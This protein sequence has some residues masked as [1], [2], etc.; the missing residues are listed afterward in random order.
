MRVLA[1]AVAA[2]LVGPVPLRAQPG[3]TVPQTWTVAAG[4]EACHAVAGA[5]LC[6]TREPVPGENRSQL[7][8]TMRVDGATWSR[9]MPDVAP[10]DVPEETWTLARRDADGDGVAEF[11]VA[12]TP[13]WEWNTQHL[14][15]TDV[16]TW[17]PSWPDALRYQTALFGEEGRGDDLVEGRL[18]V[19]EWQFAPDTTV[20][21]LLVARRYRVGS[22]TLDPTG[23]VA[24]RTFT[25]RDERLMFNGAAAWIW[26]HWL[27]RAAP[28]HTD[29]LRRLI[30]TGRTTPLRLDTMTVDW[31][32][33]LGDLYL[34]TRGSL[35]DDASQGTTLD[36]VTWIAL[37]DAGSAQDVGFVGRVGRGRADGRVDYWPVGYRAADVPAW[38]F[39]RRLDLVETTWRD[40][41]GTDWLDAMPTML[42]HVVVDR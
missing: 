20:R 3:A 4:A 27:E 22:G 11:V 17:Q 14:A 7:R 24:M 25:E 8:W 19:R 9:V 33:E 37:T 13:Q 5:E 21:P 6:R 41:D 12:R 10:S 40:A 34:G 30:D 2:V 39:G 31:A 38:L 23:E 32:F 18:V 29:P 36:G 16:W 26:D 15:P 42:L 28:V 1:V 35:P